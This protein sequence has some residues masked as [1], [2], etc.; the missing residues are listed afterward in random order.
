MARVDAEILQI[1]I[2]QRYLRLQICQCAAGAT[3][4]GAVSPASV[5]SQVDPVLTVCHPVRAIAV[6]TLLVLQLRLQVTMDTAYHCP[7]V[8]VRPLQ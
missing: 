3:V 1:R 7:Q 4:V 8:L 2:E 5:S 6:T